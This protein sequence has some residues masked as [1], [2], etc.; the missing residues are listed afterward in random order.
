MLTGKA[1]YQFSG[2]VT[3]HTD[4]DSQYGAS[5]TPDA[6]HCAELLDSTLVSIPLLQCIPV[7][8]ILQRWFL[9]CPSWHTWVRNTCYC[10]DM[11]NSKHSRPA[12][13]LSLPPSTAK[14]KAILEISQSSC[15][16]HAPHILPVLYV[17]QG[18]HIHIQ[19]DL[20][21]LWVCGPA[22]FLFLG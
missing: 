9:T 2:C 21:A 18:L 5:Y 11:K 8:P 16:A 20:N 1:P 12:A 13:H 3:T 14:K 10:H 15:R 19:G 17:F 7:L 4:S 6:R 22:S